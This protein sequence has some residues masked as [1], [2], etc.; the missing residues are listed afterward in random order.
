[1]IENSQVNT[2]DQKEV[3]ITVECG[4]LG[5]SFENT[6]KNGVL[7]RKITP[8]GQ[9]EQKGVKLGWQLMK[10]GNVNVSKK[11]QIL[12]ALKQRNEK[13]EPYTLSFK[14]PRSKPE[15]KVFLLF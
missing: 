12:N 11:S 10:V 4:T 13:R 2:T 8:G 1:M 14:I 3:V 7:V 6:G 9:V 15:S 5:F